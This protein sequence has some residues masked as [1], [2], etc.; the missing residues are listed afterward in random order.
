MEK[1]KISCPICKKIIETDPLSSTRVEIC[2]CNNP[3]FIGAIFVAATTYEGLIR[4]I[5]GGTKELTYK[6]PPAG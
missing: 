6:T 2:S 4:V 3:I 5:N 1:I